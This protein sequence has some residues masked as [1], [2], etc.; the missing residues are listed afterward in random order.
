MTQR[1]LSVQGRW[2]AGEFDP[3]EPPPAPKPPAGAPVYFSGLDLGQAQDHSALVVV[4]RTKRPD[5]ERTGG[6]VNQFDVRHLH[7]WALGTAYPQI[8]ADVKGLYAGAP[9]AGSTLAVDQTGVGRAVVDLF[10]AAGIGA[11]LCPYTIT[12]GE[13]GSGQT[14][15][16]KNL[17][18]AVQ[19]PLQ[20]QRLRFAAGLPLAAVLGKELEAFRAK[21]T[22]SRTEV[23]ESWRERDHDD[24][25]LALA[26]ALYAGS[27]GEAVFVCV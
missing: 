2:L 22:A 15:A 10:R 20:A 9:L 3:P 5:P 27:R 21:V 7:R 1:P 17:V 23:F 14:V 25:V 4:E 12:G 18:G 19:A 26:L 6:T 24:L 11:S 13:G 8:V 16:K